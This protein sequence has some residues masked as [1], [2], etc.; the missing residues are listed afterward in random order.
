MDEE[1]NNEFIEYLNDLDK[2]A[3]TLEPVVHLYAIEEARLNNVDIPLDNINNCVRK[4]YNERIGK[5]TDDKTILYKY[6]KEKERY[7]LLNV[8]IALTIKNMLEEG[9]YKDLFVL[10]NFELFSSI[11]ELF[12]N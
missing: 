11:I 8:L 1:I 12:G 6:L 10:N 9:H 3:D 5:D 7:N 4:D 2:K